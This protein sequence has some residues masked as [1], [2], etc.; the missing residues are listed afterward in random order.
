LPDGADAEDWAAVSVAIRKRMRELGLSM[1]HLARE[2][3]LSET[4]IRYIGN[5]ATGH[6]KSTLVAIAAVLRWRYDHLV[7]VLRGEPD[8]NAAGA[9]PGEAN[10]LRL[11][12]DEVDPVR[13]ELGSLRD[14]VQGMDTKMDSLISAQHP[15]PGAPGDPQEG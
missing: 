5:P 15:A 7:N 13:A 11:L 1:A 9:R 4:T 6:N 12:R 2:T 8:K 3:G 10:L 14:L